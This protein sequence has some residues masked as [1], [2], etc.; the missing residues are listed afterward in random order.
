MDKKRYYDM[1]YDYP[2]F[3]GSDGASTI[4]ISLDYF[5]TYV[6]RMEVSFKKQADDLKKEI[7]H[8]RQL[9]KP[10]GLRVVK[11]T[12]DEKIYLAEE[13]FP[14]F[15]RSSCFLSI[16]VLFEN[17]LLSRCRCVGEAQ[18][19]PLSVEDIFAYGD[20]DRYH[21]YLEK[22]CGVDFSAIVD[23]KGKD[24]LWEKFSRYRELRN[25][26]AHARGYLSAGKYSELRKY[27]DNP[28]I[29]LRLEPYKGF[30]KVLAYT[31][32]IIL[33]ENFCEMVIGDT[34]RFFAMLDTQLPEV[35]R[36]LEHDFQSKFWD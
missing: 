10:S 29:P 8:E 28:K 33:C 9:R 12:D 18:K 2:F 32:R 26:F 25:C 7:L 17:G 15:F 27:I 20:I 30:S 35:C 31:D 6:S 24:E 1:D 22:V 19:Q 36:G 34:R 4:E 23:T 3:D 11:Y 5:E 16:Y 14:N 13:V 21:K